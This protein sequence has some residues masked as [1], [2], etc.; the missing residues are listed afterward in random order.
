[1][2]FGTIIRHFQ[3]AR[4]QIPFHQITYYSKVE[5]MIVSDIEPGFS[6]SHA[7][8]VSERDNTVDKLICT[9]RIS[10][11]KDLLASATDLSRGRQTVSGLA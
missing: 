11:R 4:S 1:M 10:D 3:G 5:T 9:E 8:T 6:D 7:A 2:S